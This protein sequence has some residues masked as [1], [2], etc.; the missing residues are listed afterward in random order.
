MVELYM[1]E[2]VMIHKMKA[3][4]DEGRGSSIKEIGRELGVSRNTVRKY[5]RMQAQE[6]AEYLESPQ[7]HKLLDTYRGYLID[8]LRRYPALKTPKVYRKLKEKVPDIDISERSLRRYLTRLRPIVSDAQ[9]RYYEP[10]ID[11]VPGVQCQ[12]DGGELREVPIGGL[13]KTVYFVVFVLSFSRLMYVSLS[14][15]PIDTSIFIRMHDEAFRFFGGIPEECVYDQSKLVVIE[16]VFREVTFNE[17][18]HRYASEAGIDIWVCEGYDPESKGKVEAGVKY[19]KGDCLYGEDFADWLA[20]E[21]YVRDWLGNV[22]N[23]RIHGTTGQVPQV[24][25]D[26]Q[27][28]CQLKSYRAVDLKVALDTRKVDKT[29][30]ISYAANKYSVPM[31]YQQCQVGV[32]EVAGELVISDLDNDQEIARHTLAQGTGL[33]IKNTDHYRDHSQRISDYEAKVHEQLGDT[34]GQQLCALIKQTSPRIYKDQLAGLN[35]LIRTHEVDDSVLERVLTRPQLT[36]TQFRDY[37]EAYERHPEALNR[38]EV[39]HQAADPSLLQQYAGVTAGVQ[40]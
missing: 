19:V 16:E 32:N 22:A 34:M 1:K 2:W 40:P 3:M 33:V 26:T 11:T 10:I 36:V 12:V 24:I 5:L 30:L 38:T 17:R 21:V 28:Q 9:Q 27:E 18:F 8:L 4:Y 7:R 35:Q 29:G 37:L 31:A 20:L 15:R 25:F 39:P 14:S 6:I 13:R 23:V